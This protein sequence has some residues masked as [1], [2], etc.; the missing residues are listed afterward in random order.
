MR[1]TALGFEKRINKNAE[2]RAKFENDPTKFL[3]SEADLDAEIRT[4][5]ILSDHTELYP[6]FAKLGCTASLVSLLTHENIDIAIG[7]TEIIGELIDE[8]VQAQEEEWNALVDSMLAAD[9]SDLLLANISRLDESQPADR[10]GLYNIMGVLESLV[11]RSGFADEVGKASQ[12]KSFLPWLV[13]RATQKEKRVSQNKQY[14]AELVAI[15]LQS[16]ST[17]RSRFVADEGVDTFL[18]A[19]SVYRKKD[20]ERNSEEAEFM[21][22]LFDAL[23]C[24]SDEPAGKDK[25]LEAEG[26]ELCLIMIREGKTSKQR[27]LRLLDYS[28]SGTSGELC[29][30]KF[31]EAGGLKPFFTMFMKKQD[32]EATEHMLGMLASLLR[33]LPDESAARI[34]LLAKFVEKDYQKIARLGEIRLEYSH[35]VK[36]ADAKINKEME[37]I[38]KDEHAGFE[39]DWASTR[40]EAGLYGLQTA[41][42]ILAWLVA[43][44]DGARSKVED[45]LRT[46]QNSVADLKQSL[47]EQ[48]NGAESD[49]KE[50]LK[51]LLDV[52]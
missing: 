41:N 25:F 27:A 49:L 29:C 11:S 14:A 3:D 45:V 32:A 37:I 24:V 7:A 23:S 47:E 10:E 39:D 15:L 42:T 20:P 9:L 43:T 18:Q 51:A 36:L 48:A 21:E 44:D 40:L 8:D 6:E 38:P 26:T 52:I 1:K 50:V 19:L 16:S 5:S 35:K 2:L 30:V 17:C 28:L 4:L 31:V 13:E 46:S 12:D 33:S 22:N 34:R